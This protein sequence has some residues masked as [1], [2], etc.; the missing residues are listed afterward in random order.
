M[1]EGRE[2]TEKRRREEVEL[3]T[4][5]SET[6]LVTVLATMLA[7]ML[8]TVLATVLATIFATSEAT[9]GG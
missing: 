5:T 1:K 7:T 9:I 2:E 8:A 6:L 3:E 4:A